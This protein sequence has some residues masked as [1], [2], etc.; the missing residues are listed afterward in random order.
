MQLS[1]AQ[2]L[3]TGVLLT[4]FF[5]SG[6]AA[7]IY[8]VLWLK[9]LGL[10][11]GVTAYAA[12]TTLAVFFLG[13]SAG[14]FAWGRRSADSLRPLRVYALL[15]LGIALSAL[16]YFG[17]LDL[18]RLIYPLLFQHLGHQPTLMLL[19]KF[20]L[21]VG[22]LFLPAFFMGGTLPVMG[23][24]LVRR[25][26]E[27]G[28]KASALYA[29]NTFGAATG[30]LAAGFY[31]PPLL[32]FRNSYL[33]AV[34]LNLVIAAIAFAWSRLE[35][36]AREQSSAPAGPQ[37]SDEIQGAE[38][39]ARLIWALA[40][41]S[42]FLTLA[43]E[44]LW[45]RMFAQVLQNS[46][47]TFATILTVFLVALALG[48][49]V[50]HLLCRSRVNP[51]AALV[52]LLAAAA[53]GIG[54]IPL[55]FYRLTSGLEQLGAGLGWVEYSVSVFA[56]AAATLLIPGLLAGSIFPYLMKLSEAWRQ[57]A[58]STIG[59]L[60]A[61]NTVAAIL[62]SLAAGFLLLDL[63]GLWSSLRW[64]SIVYVLL[65]VLTL[66][67]VDRRWGRWAVC[68]IGG[69]IAIL[70]V[71]GFAIGNLRLVRVDDNEEVAW[72]R[73]GAHGTVAVVQRNGDLRLKVN[74]HYT[75][76]TAASTPNQ[77]VQA[78]FPLSLHPDPKRVFFLGMGTGI[79]AGGAL[80][81]DVERVVVTELNPDVIEASK[82]N[83]APYLNGLFEDPRVEVIAEDG[84]AY[85][86][87]TNETFDLI[88][89]DIF[90][91]YRVGV[92]SL[93]TVEHFLAVRS[94]LAP[95]GLFAQ[96]LPMFDLSEQEFGIIARTMLEVFPQV[97]LWRRSLSPRF[98]VYAL[99]ATA[100]GTPLSPDL[101]RGRLKTLEERGAV[102][103]DV[104][105]ENIPLAAFAGNVS[106]LRADFR[107]YPLSTDDWRP[108]EYLSPVTERNTK[109]A[110]RGRTLSYLE[111]AE[112]CDRL[113][114]RS[115]PRSDP[116]LERFTEREF[117]EIEAGLEYYRYATFSR[118]NR[119]TEAAEARRRYE[120]LVAGEVN[121]VQRES[122]AEQ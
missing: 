87:G 17:L 62:G 82:E 18:Y 50:A 56:I 53:V 44:V 63:L 96:W 52:F 29:I 36:P 69:A 102:G 76:G 48:S 58:G 2:K 115:E 85:L 105:F 65:A 122:P 22:I 12:A 8:E 78:W 46:V 1:S 5:F 95:G 21:A 60:A 98:P 120:E 93:Y 43:L 16:L 49:V 57:S 39:P 107:E 4:L 64:I 42:G 59:R 45:T 119:P 10:L 31:L 80:D 54:L 88:I 24:Y 103:P 101:F 84:R 6:V 37:T 11:F 114:S 118:M 38:L 28:R 99:V 79:T 121:S 68:A 112:F 106:A 110:G 109:G 35:T 3:R 108:L 26:E 89:G 25:P 23:Q 90:L 13:L 34:S 27:L 117:L 100:D 81:Y 113:L 73:E 15:E 104:W 9:E 61:V 40:F 74:N 77:R 75:L 19:V 7:L 67:R 86:A 66:F 111:L 94:R 91:T 116:F 33:L 41:A 72:L 14:S 51:A 71:T 20:M 55:V 70:V 47:Y 97:S 30:A 32:G 92:G 83:F